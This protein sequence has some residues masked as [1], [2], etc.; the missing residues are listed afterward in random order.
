MVGTSD[1]GI[2]SDASQRIVETGQV[3]ITTQ[4]SRQLSEMI[5]RN[6]QA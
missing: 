5:E 2:P 4:L 6:V 3:D 1:S